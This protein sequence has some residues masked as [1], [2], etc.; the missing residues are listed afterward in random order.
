MRCLTRAQ[1]RRLGL[2][3]ALG[4]LGAA[5][6][7]VAAA[8][9]DP[10]E[11]PLPAKGVIFSGPVRYVGDGDSLCIG[12]SSD[13]R[14]WIEIRVGDFYAPELNA[15]GGRTARDV[16]LRLTM[17]RE[18]RCR[19]DHRSYDRVVAFCTLDGRPLGELLRGAGGSQGGNGYS[20]RP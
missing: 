2:R 18:L 14:G 13:P 19:A 20:G 8:H 12:P 9:A 3:G 6:L 16:L 7:A 5:V 15:S 17:G 11:A 1:A 4:L 10:C